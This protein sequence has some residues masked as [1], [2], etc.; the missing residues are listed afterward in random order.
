MAD[1]GDPALPPRFW[2]K[3]RVA[4]SGC[5]EWMASKGSNGY[6]RFGDG[7]K[8]S[9]K[10]SHRASYEALTGP[11]P[12]GLVIDHLC[13][14]RGCVNPDHLE[15][16][17]IGENVRRGDSGALGRNKTHCPHGHAYTPANTWIASSGGRA[18]RECHRIAGRRRWRESSNG[19]KDHLTGSR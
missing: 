8:K 9:P 10:L 5:W 18:C 4:E 6:G 14:N 16:V 2:A 7:W 17:T 3:V 12:D 19:A 15:P 11:I 1:F 13:R